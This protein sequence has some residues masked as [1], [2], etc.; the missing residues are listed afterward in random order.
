MFTAGA[1][2]T[3]LYV[4]FIRTLHPSIPGGDS[5]ITHFF[6]LKSSRCH[7]VNL[8]LMFEVDLDAK[9][10]TQSSQIFLFLFAGELIVSAHELGVS[11][12]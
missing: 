11:I 2:G 3:A 12:S 6:L 4:L 9:N 1:V 7:S 8:W 10:K 5:G